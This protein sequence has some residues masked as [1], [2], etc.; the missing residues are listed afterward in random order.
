[1]AVRLA[2]AVRHVAVCRAVKLAAANRAGGCPASCR[3]AL[4]KLEELDGRVL[5]VAV[6]ASVRE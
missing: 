5:P 4:D 1:M 6:L 3:A 2:L